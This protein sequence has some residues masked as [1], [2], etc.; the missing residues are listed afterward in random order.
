M[1]WLLPVTLAVQTPDPIR[2][3][4]PDSGR[5]VDRARAIQEAFESDRHRKL[6]MVPTASGRCDERIGRFCYWYDDSDTTLPKEPELVKA[7]RARLNLSLALAQ[8]DRPSSNWLL[9]QRV[10]YL[11]EHQQPDSG[12]AVAARCGAVPWWCSALAGL[13][14]HVGRKFASA[15]SAFDVALTEMPGELRCAWTDWSVIFES[16]AADEAKGLD[17]DGRRRFADSLFLLAKPLLSEPGNDLRT[18]LLSRR[19][20]AALLAFARSPHFIP[21]GWDMEELLLRYG[22]STTWSVSDQS[23]NPLEPRGV[24]GH[25]RSPAYQFFPTRNADRGWTWNLEPDRARF[26]YAPTYADRFV[27][28]DDAQIARFPRGDSTVVVA[29]SADT[30]DAAMALTVIGH[31]PH[32]SVSARRDSSTGPGG[33]LVRLEGRPALV[34]LETRTHNDRHAAVTRL[35]YELEEPAGP[36]VVSDPL[37]FAIADDLP[38]NLEDA[39]IRALATNQISKKTPVGIY[40]EA[41]GPTGDTLHVAVTVTKIRGGLLGRRG[42]PLTLQWQASGGAFELD[43]RRQ[44]PGRYVVRLEARARGITATSRRA[45]TLLP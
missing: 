11:V 44:K 45:F 35:A 16:R 38:E 36:L 8:A 9:G 13:S 12:F 26:R 40:W 32:N 30:R 2:L 31:S 41:T 34:S 29:G 19:T 21:W 43:L 37:F 5:V 15:D 39:T 18:E 33:L 42:T 27:V 1:W 23:A 4:A 28:T 10:R 22:W 3:L 20:M 25:Q 24:T 14:L 6:P 7:A 17:C